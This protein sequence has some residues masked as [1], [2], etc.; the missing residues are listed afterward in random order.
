MRIPK[1][2]HQKS[3]GRALVEINGRRIYL[4]KF[5]TQESREMYAEILKDLDKHRLQAAPAPCPRPGSNILVEELVLSY[6]QHNVSGYYV[7]DGKPTS[8]QACIKAAL[9][10]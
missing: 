6:W 2:R 1:Y 4:G 7:K 5:G 8:E 9:R 3:T 10:W